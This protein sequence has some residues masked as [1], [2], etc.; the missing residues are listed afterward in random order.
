MIIYL[1]RHGETDWNAQRRIQGREDIPLNAAGRAQAS[2][3]GTA[4][5]G[6]GIGAVAVSPLQR[7]AETGRIIA[8]AV[9]GVP[10]YTDEDLVEREFGSW[11]GKVFADIYNP[12]TPAVGA[13]PLEEVGLRMLAALGRCAEKRMVSAA[14]VSHGGAINAVLY[15]LSGGAFGSGITRLKN[16]CI[17][18]LSGDAGGICVLAYNL[19]PE[20]FE[21]QYKN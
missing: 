18:V 10:V 6:C 4:L 3:C 9:G 17:S 14:A 13:E 20:E 15:R 11:S 12:D 21:A 1:I 16:T 8:E 19:S 7:A 5:R 2:R